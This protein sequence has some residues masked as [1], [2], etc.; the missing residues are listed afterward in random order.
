LAKGFNQSHQATSGWHHRDAI[1]P[2][3]AQVLADA[4]AQGITVGNDPTYTMT[5]L[6]YIYTIAFPCITAAETI[7]TRYGMAHSSL[8]ALVACLKGHTSLGE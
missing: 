6:G 1:H 7:A 2:P 5:E 8:V 4:L 3:P